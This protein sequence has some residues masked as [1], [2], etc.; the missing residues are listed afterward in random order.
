MIATHTRLNDLSDDM[1][2]QLEDVLL[3]FD[4]SWSEGKLAE[5]VQSL[6]PR[7]NPLRLHLLIELVKVDLERNWQH[8]RQKTVEEY[9]EAYP[10]LGTPASVAP[11]LLKTEY[12][13]RQQFGVP[14][15]LASYER[16]FPLQ[17]EGLRRLI[18][19]AHAGTGTPMSGTVELRTV[20]TSTPVPAASHDE[21]PDLPE[22]FGRYRIL[23]KLGQGSMGAVYLAHDSS[24]DRPV[25]LK[26]PRLT[27]GDDQRVRDRFYRE[28]RAAATLEHP[29]LC[30]VYDVGEINGT[31]YLTMAFVEG[32]PLSN[33]LREKPAPGVSQIVNLIHQLAV[34]LQEAH[35]RG[36]VHR[37]LKPANVM[38]NPRGEPVVMDFGLARRAE[39]Q[40]VRL[41]HTGSLIGTPAYMAPEQVQ[42]NVEALGPPCDIYALGVIM[43]EAL[44]GRL[45]FQGSLMAVLAQIASQEPEP[46][47]KLRPDLD[48]ALG[49][50]CR[51]A[52]AKKP[53]DRYASMAEL[54]ADLDAHRQLPSTSA[55]KRPPRRSRGVAIAAGLVAVAG[56]IL[57]VIILIRHRDG[58]T[59]KIIT[60][61][62]STVEVRL[63]PERPTTP[64]ADSK[65]DNKAPT[66]P[67]PAWDIHPPGTYALR[68]DGRKSR[69]RI[70]KSAF[71]FFGG[72]ALTIEVTVIP[73]WSS[74]RNEI[75]CDLTSN[76]GLSLA[77]KGRR[78]TFGLGVS[79]KFIDV[80]HEEPATLDRR[81]HL[82]GVA[83]FR[84]GRRALRLFVDGKLN[85]AETDMVGKFHDTP[86]DT[87]LGADPNN[88]G[89]QFVNFF[90]GFIEQVR[91]SKVARY[92]EDYV[93]KP[94]FDASDADDDTM[95]LYLC[96]E[97]EGNILHDSSSR[98]GHA[99][100][101]GATWV[102]RKP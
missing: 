55:S 70:P 32:Q 15:E 89:D 81:V 40:E 42:G 98:K 10:E 97:G 95:V 99:R 64:K 2:R 31:P 60:D 79:S 39:P 37:D 77:L 36:V 9:L 80:T 52:M 26:V 5:T 71:K 94:L 18:D 35:A 59:T 21:P 101:E 50:I 63:E 25:A 41:T 48:P 20:E 56:L 57:G 29:N 33:V 74:T 13:V 24:L 53:A 47:A 30:P 17:T 4:H 45:P 88:P 54:A 72:H 28:A 85:K 102:K 82:A 43:Y 92:K 44:A 68:F 93:P 75:V 6:P 96:N 12:E 66:P 16:R 69:V 27:L 67:R 49:A 58:S 38:L 19:Q 73:R 86:W 76:A 78:W 100:I 84:D 11:H 90:D 3:S 7:A 87:I 65:T 22:Q 14:A 61:P 1:R 83:G 23:R 34:A 91:I 46:L 8:G 62:G 51:K